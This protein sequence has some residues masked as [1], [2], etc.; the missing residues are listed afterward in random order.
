MR[1]KILYIFVVFLLFINQI[2]YS[3]TYY[4]SPSGNDSHTPDQA[5]SKDFPWKSITK[6]AR[7]VIAGDSIVVMDGIY[8]ESNIEFTNS[9]NSSAWITIINDDNSKPIL[10]GNGE[11]GIYIRGVKNNPYTKSHFMLKG[12]TIFGYQ[13]DGISIF[14][15]DFIVCDD[16]HTYENGNAGIEVVG[17]NHIIIQNSK[18]HHNGWKSDGDSGWGDGVSINNHYFDDPEGWYSIIRSKSMY[19]NWQKRD[20][21]FW[22]GNGFTWDMA[23]TGGIHIFANN[24]IFNNGG[25]GFLT[26]KTGNMILVHNVFFRNMSDYNRC[27][28]EGEVQLAGDW[29]ESTI[30]KNNIIYTREKTSTY[31]TLYPLSLEDAILIPDNFIQH[32]LLWGENGESTRIY[33]LRDI[34]LSTWVQIA[35]PSTLTGD[36]EFLSAP[37]DNE[38]GTLRG[39]EWINMIFTDYDFRLSEKS[40]CI[41]SGAFL[42][43]TLQAGAGNII[44][45]DN[46]NHFTDGFRIKNQGNL[47]QIGANMPVR[48]TEIDYTRNLLT[49]DRE[50]IWEKNDRVSFP[51]AGTAPDLGAIEHQ[52]DSSIQ[53]PHGLNITK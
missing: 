52:I 53:A 9:G 39:Q 11:R 38:F 36:P 31:S 5:T 37:F 2:L 1:V 7:T 34:L 12:L 32:N 17:S 26:S 3:A 25:C 18:L 51:Y 6:A 13:Q 35:S 44:Q 29:V 48:I 8:K 22:D 14:W 28:N 20:G 50:L 47:I 4:V 24:L 19:A 45:V 30:I 41:D 16:I 40:K 21:A 42:T 43:K 49:V 10:T 23:G 27:R 33:W 15:S 46:A